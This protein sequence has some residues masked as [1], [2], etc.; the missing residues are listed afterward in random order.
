LDQTVGIHKNN[1]GCEELSRFIKATLTLTKR[2]DSTAISHVKDHVN[3]D[4]TKD[5]LQ[6]TNMSWGR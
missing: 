4:Q 5:R 2:L 3:L 6:T 1:L